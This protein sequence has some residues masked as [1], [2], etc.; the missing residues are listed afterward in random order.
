VGGNCYTPSSETSTPVFGLPETGGRG[1]ILAQALEA[2][3][4][5]I[6]QEFTN[7]ILMQRGYQANSRVIVTTDELTQE[8]INLKR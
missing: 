4:V 2:S 1:K 7:L 5:D 3:T 8:T 6:A